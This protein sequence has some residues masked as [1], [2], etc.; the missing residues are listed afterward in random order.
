MPIWPGSRMSIRGRG[1][2]AVTDRSALATYV[3]A[4]S[5]CQP[6]FCA[7]KSAQITPMKRQ[8]NEKKSPI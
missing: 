4:I 2:G 7:S 5:S 1:T 6:C 8:W 3:R